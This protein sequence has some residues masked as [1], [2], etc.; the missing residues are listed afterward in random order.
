MQI[1]TYEFQLNNG[2][3]AVMLPEESLEILHRY[4]VGKFPEKM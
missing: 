4:N 1:S 2:K 3:F